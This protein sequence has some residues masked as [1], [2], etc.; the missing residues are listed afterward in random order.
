MVDGEVFDTTPEMVETGTQN[1]IYL[2]GEVLATIDDEITVD[3]V[4]DAAAG[5]NLKKFTVETCSG[6]ALRSAD[7]PY[8]GSLR[9]VEYNAAKQQ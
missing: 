9:L 5:K 4:K 2:R 6:R 1:K 7:F 8:N 3:D